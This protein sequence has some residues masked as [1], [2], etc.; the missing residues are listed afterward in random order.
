MEYQQFINFLKKNNVY[1]KYMKN[2][3]KG[4]HFM[5]GFDTV[6]ELFE[7][8]IDAMFA[9]GFNWAYTSDG[10]YFWGEIHTKWLKH[11]KS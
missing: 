3:Y 6:E 4:S 11:I 9:E 1:N 2:F 5:S 8:N 7:F 10:H